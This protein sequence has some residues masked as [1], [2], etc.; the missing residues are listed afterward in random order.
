MSRILLLKLVVLASFTLIVG[1]LAGAA[2]TPSLPF[3]ATACVRVAAPPTVDG[4]LDDAC[5]WTTRAMKPFV[6]LTLGTADMAKL[7]DVSTSAWVGGAGTLACQR[8]AD[9]S[10][11][12]TNECFHAVLQRSIG[13]KSPSVAGRPS[14]TIALRSSCRERLR[15]IRTGSA[16]EAGFDKLIVDTAVSVLDT[17]KG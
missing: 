11:C 14:E 12:P 9:K 16:Y 17:L 4:K 10:V 3:V 6:K 8:L 2:E 1:S 15:Q 7:I 5:W 13:Q